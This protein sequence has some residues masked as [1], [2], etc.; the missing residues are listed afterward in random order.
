MP[1]GLRNHGLQV[2][3]IYRGRRRHDAYVKV[4]NPSTDITAGTQLLADESGRVQVDW[5]LSHA[6]YAERP[7]G[8]QWLRAIHRTQR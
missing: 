2:Q 5:R 8:T 3:N 4:F 7:G 1:A 6:E